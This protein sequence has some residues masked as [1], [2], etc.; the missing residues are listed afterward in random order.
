MNIADEMYKFILESIEV[1]NFLL[2]PLK[3]KK[4]LR[5]LSSEKLLMI[6]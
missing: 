2:K 4:H 1:L 6:R 3:S 5:I